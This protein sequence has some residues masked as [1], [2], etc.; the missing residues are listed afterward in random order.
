MT[1][2]RTLDERRSTE[3]PDE[4]AR[5]SLL[6]SVGAI[7]GGFAVSACCVLPLAFVTI[8]VGGSFMGTLV[9]F[10]P[11]KIITIP[12][13]LMMLGFGFYFAYRTPRGATCTAD[14]TCGTSASRRVARGLLWFGTIVAAIGIGFPYVAP[15][16]L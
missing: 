6:L 3:S 8:G 4:G 2:I 15:A 16:L 14:G 10:Q 13:T 9:A 11:Y 7:I 1:D 5:R 12:L